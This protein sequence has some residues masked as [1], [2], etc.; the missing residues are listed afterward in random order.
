MFGNDS[1]G[2]GGVRRGRGGEGVGMGGGFT[3]FPK[4]I[5]MGNFVPTVSGNRI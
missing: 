1:A 3:K 4:S 2:G 5:G